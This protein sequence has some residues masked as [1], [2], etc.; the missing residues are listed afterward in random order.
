MTVPNSQLLLIRAVQAGLR[1]AKDDIAIA[2]TAA[3]GLMTAAQNAA[4]WNGYARAYRGYVAL[5][6]ARAAV[7]RAHVECSAAVLEQ[8]PADAPTII[9]LGGARK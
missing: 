2:E 5:L 1:D 4:D 8:Y 7:H 3:D 6:E 9:G